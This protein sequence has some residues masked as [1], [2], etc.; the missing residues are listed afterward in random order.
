MSFSELRWSGPRLPAGKLNLHA[1]VEWVGCRVVVGWN[2]AE[3]EA[4]ARADEGIVVANH[5]ECA[6]EPPATGEAFCA[7]CGDPAT[8]TICGQPYCSQHGNPQPIPERIGELIAKER[9]LI[10]A[11]ASDVY[12]LDEETFAPPDPAALFRWAEAH[13]EL[14]EKTAF[15]QAA[16]GTARE[17]RVPDRRGMARRRLPGTRRGASAIGESRPD[18]DACHLPM[19]PSS[20]RHSLRKIALWRLIP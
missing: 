18:P 12:Q 9:E 2:G 6:P 8:R 16:R 5:F 14:K 15:R 17:S 20:I 13:A 3:R 4:A 7:V 1:A 10:P 11:L 19:L